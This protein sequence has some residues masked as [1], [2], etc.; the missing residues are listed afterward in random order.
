MLTG[1]LQIGNEMGT[2][3]LRRLTALKERFNTAVQAERGNACQVCGATES[4]RAHQITHRNQMPYGGF[5]VENG[6]VLCRECRRS[7]RSDADGFSALDLY[8]IID[9]SQ[10]AAIAV[11]WKRLSKSKPSA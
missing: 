6:I 7:A 8:A 5:C 11:I 9:S 1:S 2:N 4:G 3:S 10:Q